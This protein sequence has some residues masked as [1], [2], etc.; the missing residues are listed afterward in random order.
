[1]KDFLN[2]RVK[3]REAFRPF[4]PVVHSDKAGDYFDVLDESPFM[5]LAPRVR[6]DKLDVIPSAIHVDGTARLQ[7]LRRETNPRYWDVIDAFGARTGVYVV[8]NTSLNRRGEPIACAPEDAVAMFQGSD[9]D[10]LV[11]GNYS[12]ER[13]RSG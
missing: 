12:V 5:T 2:E 4:A 7:T 9:M 3:H 11:L 8:L 13:Q 10:V 6:R 1:M